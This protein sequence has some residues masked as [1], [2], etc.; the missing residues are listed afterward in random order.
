[1]NYLMSQISPYKDEE[2]N[3]LIPEKENNSSDK[4]INSIPSNENNNQ[5][6]ISISI[7]PSND[8]NNEINIPSTPMSKDLNYKKNKKVTF[9]DNLIYINY[10]EDEYVTNIFLS[11]NN[12]RNLPHKEKDFAKYL[13]I[14]TSVSHTSKLKPILVDL[15]KKNKNKKKTKIMKRNI[16]YLKE[17]AKTGNV[18]STSKDR[19]KKK[20]NID[21]AKGCKKFL[22]NP[23][24]F[25]TEDLCDAVL[26]SYNLDPKEH[27][28][29][30]NSAKKIKDKK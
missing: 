16:E 19:T 13:R 21:N 27:L 22:E 3:Q 24:Q 28:S 14:L 2:N 12:G 5:K 30:G 4:Y 25:F 1:M 10:D 20:Y 17:V 29:R 18:F 7:V 11:D 15:N 9:D 6:R 8:D 26:L 23:Q